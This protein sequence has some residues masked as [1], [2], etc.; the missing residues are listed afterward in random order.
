[1]I[2]SLVANIHNCSPIRA[3]PQKKNPTQT[4]G[5]GEAAEVDAGAVGEAAAGGVHVDAHVVGDLAGG[6]LRAGVGSCGVE[7]EVGLVLQE[8]VEHVRCGCDGRE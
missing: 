6:A 2:Q 5:Y 3:P 7:D 1:M 4:R 8:P